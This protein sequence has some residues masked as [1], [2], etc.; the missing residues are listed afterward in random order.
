M[1][2]FLQFALNLLFNNELRISKDFVKHL[3]IKFS[4]KML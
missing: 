3:T 2:D 4:D 1:K